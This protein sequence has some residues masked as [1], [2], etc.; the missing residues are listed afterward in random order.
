MPACAQT[1][2]FVEPGMV[3]PLADAAGRP[4]KVGPNAVTQLIA[5]FEAAG[6]QG[7]MRRTFAEAGLWRLLEHPPTEM[8]PE[9]EPAFL[10]RAM[11]SVCPA[12]LS[13]RIAID[14]GRRTADYVMANRIPGFAKALLR[15]LPAPFAAPI[16]AK[17]IARHAWTFCGSGE[18]EV[19]KAGPR[20]LTITIRNN[21]LATPGCPWH[22]AVFERMFKRLAGPRATVVHEGCEGCGGEACRF[23]IAF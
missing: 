5:A 17:A 16:L 19:A 12:E 4:A 20:K 1:D 22:T 7:M 3:G 18:V 10:H 14:A 6:E 15:A 21:A 13:R 2:R 23:A 9:Y 11:L 8:V